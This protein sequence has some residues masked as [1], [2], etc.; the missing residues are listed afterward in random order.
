M[1]SLF[2]QVEE[3]G[4]K[5][6]KLEKNKKSELDSS[7]K[8]MIKDIKGLKE[9]VDELEMSVELFKTYGFQPKQF[10]QLM[11]EMRSQ[12]G[13]AAKVTPFTAN[14]ESEFKIINKYG[15][16]IASVLINLAMIIFAFL[17]MRPL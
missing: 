4:D 7:T 5:D 12:K 8:Q 1:E 10:D 11:N 17:I 16:L 14:K 2:E 3:E 13:I 15:I 9:R 6:K